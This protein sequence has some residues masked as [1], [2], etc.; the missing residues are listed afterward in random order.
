MDSVR[1]GRAIRK[2]VKARLEDVDLR[3]RNVTILEETP[4]VELIMIQKHGK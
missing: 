4:P 3:G 1:G 2:V